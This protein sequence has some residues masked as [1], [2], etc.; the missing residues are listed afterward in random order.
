MSAKEYLRHLAGLRGVAIILVVLF[1]MNG[2]AWPHGYLGVDVFLVITG[3]LLFRSRLAAAEPTGVVEAARFLGK[4]VQ[5]IVPPMLA[6]IALTLTAGML[7]LWWPDEQ[8]CGKLGYAACMAKANTLL[9]REFADYFA[10]DSAFIPL[11]HLW[12][13][14]VTLQVYLLYAVGNQLLQRLPK[15]AA[16]GVLILLGAASLLYCYHAPLA[17]YMGL[18]AGMGVSYYDTLPR[19]WEV[20][21]GGLV[22]VLPGCRR[23]FQA[24]LLTLVG[25]ALILIPAVAGGPAPQLMVVAGTAL[26]LR[27]APAGRAQLLLSNKALVWLGGISFSLYLVHMPLIVFMR[28][29]ALGESGALYSGLMLAVSLAAG[30]GFYHAVEKRRAAWWLTLALW[31]ATLFYCRA[32]RRT[33]GFRPYLPQSLWE[34]PTYTDWRLCTDAALA[35]GLEEFPTFDGAFRMMNQLLNMPKNAHAPLLTMGESSPKPRC[36]LIGD[37]H[38][39]HT[40][41][42]LDATLRHLGIPGIYLASYIYPLHGWEEDKTPTPTQPSA[43]ELALLRWL[44]AHPELT[45]VIIA[46][47]WWYRFE[48]DAEQTAAALHTF[49]QEIKAAGKHAV[50][51]GPTPEF[52]GQPALLHFNKIYALRGMSAADAEAAAATCSREQYLEL[53]SYALPLLVQLQEEGL[54]TLIEPLQ[55]LA[56]G[57]VFRSLA[58]GQLLMTDGNHMSP[59]QSINLMQKL[60]DQLL[61]ALSAPT[62]QN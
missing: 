55:T 27:Y 18:S 4:R 31:G 7:F 17:E 20:L 3:Y 32:A 25:L 59:G 14:S 45:H 36:V 9:S 38:A 22:C 33:E 42:G 47:R 19:V 54:C 1:H 48:R 21:A 49:L 43:R 15:A 6:V 16:V 13:L 61:R 37:S 23:E 56:P 62:P 46:Q 11:L 57:E 5:R 52:T 53:N 30:Y 28:M 58:G 40:Y 50:I 10:S 12:Y 60:S 26:T 35:E 8:F 2:E 51:I 44:A 29:V 41:A 34:P 24:T 39:A